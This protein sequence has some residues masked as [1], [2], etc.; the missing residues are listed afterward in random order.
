MFLVANCK[1]N[2]LRQNKN[3]VKKTLSKCFTVYVKIKIWEKNFMKSKKQSFDF[4]KFESR[5]RICSSYTYKIQDSGFNEN[6][7]NS[8][9]SERNAL[10]Q[11]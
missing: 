1:K 4:Q 11:K 8:R 9:G 7:S 2:V 6:H 5:V 10:R 3:F